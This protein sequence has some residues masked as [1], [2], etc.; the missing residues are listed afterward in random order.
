MRADLLRRTSLHGSYYGSDKVLLAELAM[1]GRIE[2]VPEPLFIKRFHKDTSYYLTTRER[3]AWIDPPPRPGAADRGAQRLFPGHVA[4]AADARAARALPGQHR[5][6][7]RQSADAAPAAAA[8]AGQLSGHRAPAR[9]SRLR[10]R[11]KPAGCRPA[12]SAC[13]PRNWRRC[14][15]ISRSTAATCCPPRPSMASGSRS[16]SSFWSTTVAPGSG[17]GASRP[18]Q[19]P[20]ARPAAGPAAGRR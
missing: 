10:S 20:Q 8:G 5:P 14:W 17:P 7:D 15:S 11:T 16:W 18:D 4:G 2:S 13:R 1:L 6:Q 12:S 19:V 3:A 9:R